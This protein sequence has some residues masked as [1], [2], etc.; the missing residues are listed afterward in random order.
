[1]RAPDKICPG[2][3]GS[4]IQPNWIVCDEDWAR[5]PTGLRLAHVITCA[6]VSL[7]HLETV[8]SIYDWC[9]THPPMASGLPRAAHARAVASGQHVVRAV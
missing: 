8:Q 1:M 3:C 4:V 9:K 6:H 2:G 7:V 5:L